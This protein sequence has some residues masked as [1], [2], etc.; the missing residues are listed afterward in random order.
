[1]DASPQFP[2]DEN[3]DVFRRMVRDGDDLTKPR[4]I[5]FCHIF[6]ERKQALAFAE[7]IDDRDLKVCISYYEAQDMWQVI[8]KRHM[9]PTYRDVT[10][11]ELSLAAKAESLGGEPD[12]WGCMIVK[13][14]ETT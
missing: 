7:E 9:I 1:M 11:L 14:K 4:V 8:V 2:S 3:G 6:T 12:G 5:D 10:S 13:R